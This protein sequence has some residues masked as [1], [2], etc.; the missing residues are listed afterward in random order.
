MK[1][2]VY[3]NLSLDIVSEM[4][5]PLPAQVRVRAPLDPLRPWMQYLPAEQNHDADWYV[6]PM[7]IQ[8]DNWWRKNNEIDTWRM[9]HKPVLQYDTMLKPFFMNL[10]FFSTYPE[11]HIFFQ[12]GDCE[13]TLPTIK[14][15]IVLKESSRK[16]INDYSMFYSP[17]N[18]DA[19]GTQTPITEAKYVASFQGACNTH[20]I[21]SHISKALL[22]VKGKTYYNDTN[23]FF[24]NEVESA[25]KKRDQLSYKKSIENS[26]FVL[27]PRGGGFNSFRFFECL[28][29]G[30]I[31]VLISDRIKLPLEWLIDYTDF[32]VKV[33]EPQIEYVGRFIEMFKQKHDLTTASKRAR[34]T[35][36]D[37]FTDAGIELFLRRVIAKHM[38]VV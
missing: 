3:Q 32:V 20:N 38:G 29:A 28:C 17:L 10:D 7:S 36:E 11:K 15:G 4:G 33:P 24:F 25:K 5:F 34:Q 19:S 21:R 12:L 18:V 37:Y 23:G 31:P 14:K 27:C 13:I 9:I 1:L 6:V 26:Q 35:Y 30:R 2:H 22:N 8:F 16:E